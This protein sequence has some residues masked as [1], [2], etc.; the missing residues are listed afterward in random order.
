MLSVSEAL[1]LVLEETVPLPT[2][3]IPLQESRGR[4][5]RENVVSDVDIPPFDKALMDGYAL[6][7]EDVAAGIRTFQVVEEILAGSVP[8]RSL[9]P[10][11]TARIMTGGPVPS[12]A[13]AVVIV[14][15]SELIPSESQ[16]AQVRIQ[17]PK[18]LPEQNLLRRGAVSWAGQSVVSS[19]I[20]LRAQEIG[21]C[22]EAGCATLSVNLQPKVAIL[23]T[24]DELVPA[25]FPLGPGQIR[26][27]NEPM[28]AAQIEDWGGIPRQLGIA[29]DHSAPL[30]A[31][32]QEGLKSDF[33][34]LSGGVSAGK[35]DLVPAQLAAAGVR[36]VFHKIQ[37]RPGKPLW[38][39]V[40]E[41]ENPQEDAHRCL[42]FG[43]PGNPVS[44]MVC[45][46]LF[47]RPALRKSQGI[48]PPIVPALNV[49]L[50]HPFLMQGERPTYHPARIFLD[51]TELRVEIVDWIGS[52]DLRSTVSANGTVFLPPGEKQYEIGDVLGFH[53]WE[54]TDLVRR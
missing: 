35:R 47:V 14:E 49:R 8:Q 7:S 44:S 5:L 34:L 40:Y 22:V 18:V 48:A 43:L 23:A 24:G 4:I 32:I 54:Q 17:V 2:V 30:F 6:R 38:F 36:Q 46:D 3:T 25:G 13:D 37:M 27:S 26:N 53:S 45:A 11:E 33:L 16:V 15:Q 39:G 10:G 21:A 31:S 50:S 51:G 29:P 20:L 9:G 12:G 19:G 28:L 41:T 42:V 52:S 1:K